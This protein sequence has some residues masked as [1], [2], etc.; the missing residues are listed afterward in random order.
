MRKWIIAG[1]VL[2]VLGVAAV[3]AILNANSLIR[4]NK[5]YL[6]TRAEEALGRRLQVGD[7]Q[8]ALWGGLGVRLMR[9]AMADDPAFSSGEFVRAA[10]LQVNVKL[11]PLLRKQLEVKKI[12]LHDPV[13]HIVRSERG[14]FNFST[15]GKKEKE[16]KEKEPPGRERDRASR[17]LLISVVDISAGHVRYRD[18]KEGANVELRDIDLRVADLDFD[19]PFT[20]EL[21]AALFAPKQNLKLKARLGPLGRDGVDVVRLPLDG[22]L[23]A[24]PLDMT[25]LKAALPG[26]RSWLPRDLDLS[27][28]FRV[29]ELKFKG[30]LLDLAV[31]GEIEGRD[32]VI[33]YGKTFHKPAGV[34]LA[35]STDARY[36]RSGISVRRGDLQL[37]TLALAARGDIRLGDAPALDLSFDSRPASLEGWDKLVPALASYQLSGRF[38][39]HATVRGR[40]GGGASPQIQGTLSLSGASAR[41]PQFSKPVK[42]LNTRINFTGQRADVQETTF[43]L[44]SSRI[45]LAAAV[46]R[47]SPLTL[48]YRIS[49]P[50]LIP[51]EYQAEISEARRVDAIKNLTSEGQLRAHNGNVV[52]QAKLA[53]TDGT[54][55]RIPYKGLEADLSLANKVATIRNLRMNALDGSLQLEGEY[56][57]DAPTPHFSLATRARGIDIQRLYAA[58]DARAQRDLRGKLNADV[59]VNGGGQNWEQIKARLRGQGEAEVVQGALLNFNLAEGVLSGITG[60][61]GLT[62]LINPRIRSKYPE[63]F[64]AKDTEFRELKA[65]LDLGGARIN[66]KSLRIA[67]ADFSVQGN[68]WA[69][70]DRRV[71]FRSV[72][73]FSPRLSAD[74]ASSAR[75][76][77]YLFNGQG[78]MEVPFALAGTLPNVRPR[79]DGDYLARMVQRG[80][81]QK[82]AEEIQRRFFGRKEPDAA[83][84][85]PAPVPL[86]P[87]R[88]R[89]ESPD[90]LIRKGLD[91][92]FG[93]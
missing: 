18:R 82:G 21:A 67:A 4:R 3:V 39:L 49:T 83:R 32:G 58:I 27:G 88:R 28:V 76:V 29:K 38:E 8:L 33:A 40:T 14:E 51:A 13:I 78:Q 23:T 72:L 31:A 84:D 66:V 91:R 22:Q 77:R 2:F 55:Y 86:E 30:T 10:D 74:I 93:R 71:D 63:T 15:I 43:T 11:W 26:I 64:A 41:P 57:F 56:A 36:G 42:D 1:T 59:K 79:P 7:V 35:V 70:F 75:E 52:L 85:Q 9:F 16:K 68:G 60:I 17:A 61:P 34:P 89:R 87:E 46:E 44:G 12:I 37:H 62:N 19:R 80:F 65:L 20:V 47:F 81:L 5:D 45:R 73:Q 69:D 54:L 6:L 24:D 90:D 25:R 50:E 48:T 53:S 92:L